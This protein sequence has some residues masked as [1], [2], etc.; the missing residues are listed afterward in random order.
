MSLKVY[1]A[2]RLKRSSDY[3]KLTKD[4]QKTATLK[5]RTHLAELFMKLMD[6]V[7][8][9]SE[10]Y[11]T[12][13]QKGTSE[14]SLRA[15][16]VDGFLRDMYKE[17][18]ISPYRSTFNFDVSVA[19]REYRGR[20]Y[21]IPYADIQGLFDFLEEDPRLEDYHYQNQTDRP[22]T[23]SRTEWGRRARVWNAL[24]DADRW[25]YY[26]LVDICSFSNWWVINPYYDLLW[27]GAFGKWAKKSSPVAEIIREAIT[28]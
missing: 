28:R 19:F 22:V 1:E 24:S 14:G 6:G 21:L 17:S 27:S 15:E 25:S 18:T 3:W 20:V 7:D 12:G 11:K 26:T 8:V 5:L 13:I 10:K 2:Y 23:I 9:N 16:I 4:I